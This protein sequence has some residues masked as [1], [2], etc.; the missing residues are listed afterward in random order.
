M[1]LRD[2]R[3]K[4]GVAEPE[5]P[6]GT[7]TRRKVPEKTARQKAT[8]T[9]VAGTLT[10]S[11][12]QT[13]MEEVFAQR[14]SANVPFSYTTTTTSSPIIYAPQPGDLLRVWDD[15]SNSPGPYTYTVSPN[16]TAVNN[17]RHKHARIEV[18]N[19]T[20]EWLVVCTNCTDVLGRVSMESVP[21]GRGFV[22]KVGPHYVVYDP[23][24]GQLK[25]RETRTRNDASWEKMREAHRRGEVYGRA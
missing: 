17:C 10:E 9:D 2:W 1:T 21:R 16:G 13:W 5:D 20:L 11:D 15:V 18:S 7:R 4:T 14:H 19:P 6:D 22:K 3:E 8:E 25:L 23:K 24:S 12:I